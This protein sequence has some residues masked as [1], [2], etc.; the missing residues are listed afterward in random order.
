MSP[1][2]PG[3]IAAVVFD[4]DGVLLDTTENMRIAF[5]AAWQAA[6]RTTEPP[7]TEFLTRMGAPL[8]E[9]LNAFGLPPA[10]SAVYATASSAHLDLVHAFPGI[11][12]LLQGLRSIAMPVAVATGKSQQRALQALDAGG[13][14]DYVDVVVG[15]DRVP[16]PKPAPDSLH[17]A[18]AELARAGYPPASTR[19]TVFIGDSVLDMRCGRAAGAI[20]VGAGW[21]QT[22][23]TTLLAEGPD[24]LAP[25]CADLAA[26]LG[27][28]TTT[29]GAAGGVIR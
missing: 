29:T 6:G 12:E 24:A 19:D 28:Q 5:T 8:S 15:S 20:V 3:R 11:V 2:D 23:P 27:R 18:L 17:L 9:I 16:H 1:I 26:L 7:F 4:L 10:T 21:G 13:L 14:S 25:T 22:D